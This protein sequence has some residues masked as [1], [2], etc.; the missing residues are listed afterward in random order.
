VVEWEE[1]V[2]VVEVRGDGRSERRREIAPEAKKL[3]KQEEEGNDFKPCWV[4]AYIKTWG[5]T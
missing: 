5:A 3:N 2:E 4:L 1:M